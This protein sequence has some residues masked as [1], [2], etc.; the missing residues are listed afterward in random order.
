MG[1]S[2][3][4][5]LAFSLRL[6]L[7]LAGLLLRRLEGGVSNRVSGEVH[8]DVIQVG[9]VHGDLTI[10]TCAGCGADENG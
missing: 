9:T 8:G 2:S 1:R 3:P 4:G 5:L 7:G 6:F 10:R